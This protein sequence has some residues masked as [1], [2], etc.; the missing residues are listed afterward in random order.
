MGPTTRTCKFATAFVLGVAVSTPA[1]AETAGLAAYL[2]ARVAGER[3]DLGRAVADFS[4]AL[5][6]AP[7]VL[8]AIR[9]YRDALAGGDMVL[10]ERAL[11][12]LDKAGVTPEDA[13]LLQVARAAQ[14]G[15]EKAVAAGAVKLAQGRLTI[16]VPVIRAWVAQAAGRDPFSALDAAEAEPVGRRLASETRVMFLIAAGREAEALALLQSL[17]GPD[18]SIDLRVAAAQLL[19][20][21]GKGELARRLFPT[22]EMAIADALARSP[23]RPSLGFGVSRLFARVASDLAGGEG[24][25]PLGVTLTR[26]ALLAEPENDRARLLLA[27]ALAKQGATD[28]ALAL[29]SEVEPDRPFADAAAGARVTVLTQSDR[30]PEALMD[31]QRLAMRAEAGRGDWQIY[32]DLLVDSGRSAEAVPFY[33]RIAEGEGADEWVVWMQLGGALEQAG[34]WPAARAALA[35]AVELGPD[36]PIALN[37]LGYARLTRG[38]AKRESARLLER[39]HKL[40]PDNASIADSLGWAYHLTGDT[41]RAL[42]L[43][44]RAATEE[45]GNAEIA[46]H[47]GDVYWALGR[48]YEARYAWT[49][50]SLVAEPKDR[51]KLD[52][53]VSEGLPSR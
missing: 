11:A 26:A 20:S 15:D 7:D 25:N 4:R 44:E 3:G 53:K 6:D 48:R 13:A 41:A 21:R 16:L 36:E 30:R 42:P 37:Y 43:L 12:I 46:E 23:I 19:G 27:N 9:A 52:R 5:T 24:P 50:A 33:R 38:E 8:V 47:L 31:A 18:A 34:N 51:A 40:A 2:R 28:R 32:A 22:D 39:A 35:R 45:P 14:R 1:L 17:G 10:A 29:L 49:A